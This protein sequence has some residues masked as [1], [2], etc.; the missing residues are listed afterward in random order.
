MSSIIVDLDGTLAN[1]DHRVHLVQNK[2]PQWDAFFE[3]CDKDT[4]ITPVATLV[5]TM[6]NSDLFQI[7]ILSG[8]M[9]TVRAKTERWLEVNGVYYHHLVMRKKGDFRPD[10]IVKKEMLF[11]APNEKVKDDILFILED[12]DLVVK[13]WRDLGYTCLQVADGDF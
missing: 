5:N 11:K 1:L 8:R 12:R 4:L 3:L 2:P 7:V 6:Y 10:H 9:E 13:M